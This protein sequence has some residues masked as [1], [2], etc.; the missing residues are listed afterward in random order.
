MI[1]ALRRA[2]W[3]IGAVMGDHDYA[4]YVEVHRRKH[5]DR[6]PL[7]ERDYWRERHAAADS[8]P[9]SRCC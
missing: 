9:G 8:N 5:P 1:T 2:W 6:P 3:W 7:S 4:R